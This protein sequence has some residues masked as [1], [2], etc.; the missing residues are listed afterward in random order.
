MTPPLT[1]RCPQCGDVALDGHL[2]CGRAAC[3]EGRQRAQRQSGPLTCL[4]YRADGTL[5]GERATTVD[6]VRMIMVC[7]E[8]ATQTE[9]QAT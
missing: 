6:T 3:E 2:T 5:C 4:A 7:P 1:P 8:H 9:E